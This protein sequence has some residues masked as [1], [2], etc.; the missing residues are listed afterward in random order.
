MFK[1]LLE[2]L[3]PQDRGKQIDDQE[4]GDDDPE[5]IFHGL[6]PF[7]GSRVQSAEAEKKNG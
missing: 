6:Q 4:E 1:R 5:K 7:T 3:R 2:F